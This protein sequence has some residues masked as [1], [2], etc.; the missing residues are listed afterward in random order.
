MNVGSFSVCIMAVRRHGETEPT[1]SS[2]LSEEPERQKGY[3]GVPIEF[4]T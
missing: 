1:Q 4:L 3:L 2:S